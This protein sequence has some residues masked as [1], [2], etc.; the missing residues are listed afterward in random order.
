L[1]SSPVNF[2]SNNYDENNNNVISKLNNFKLTTYRDTINE[3]DNI[4]ID[5]DN[6]YTTDA[7]DMKDDNELNKFS[8]NVKEI[9]ISV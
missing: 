4:N 7:K 5:S 8:K 6:R 9:N 1:E 3:T 2:N